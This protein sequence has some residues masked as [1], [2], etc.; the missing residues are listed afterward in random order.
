M[1]AGTKR[2][3]AAPKP[4]KITAAALRAWPLPNPADS[5][6]K[7]DRGR[8]L[9]V[10][11]SREVPGSVLLAGI[12]A[13]RA[14]AG[15]LQ[16]ATASDVA[17]A[18]ALALPE[19]RVIGLHAD[20]RGAI[21]RAGHEVG[22]AAM[23]ADAVLAGPGMRSTA[24]TQ[25]VIRSLIGATGT[26]RATLVLDAG[27]LHPSVVRA[28]GQRES[29]G[30][31]VMTP[32][33]GEMAALL[34][35]TKDAITVDPVARARDAARDWQVVLV[36]KGPTTCIATPGG[37]VWINTGGSVGLGTSGSG[38]VLAGIIAGLAARGAAPEQAAAWG[39]Y[40][41]ARAGALLS[42]RV[43]RVGFLAREI[44]A[45]VPGLLQKL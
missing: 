11:G 25:R 14:G 37:A 45:L 30:G 21:D 23:H 1:S 24:A 7:E 26:G 8:V 29:R 33:A 16:V 31:V 15:K 35:T 44:A 3:P 39:V 36:L 5:D 12:A 22:Q 6:S 2:T 10:G 28:L 40:L 43:G 27:A 34:G 4:G 18:M 17:V 38:D 32:H 9:V 20:A 41:H 19:A 42:R 13:L